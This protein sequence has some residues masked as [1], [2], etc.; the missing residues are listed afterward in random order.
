MVLEYPYTLMIVTVAN[1][2]KSMY[3]KSIVVYKDGENV[4]GLGEMAMWGD[5]MSQVTFLSDGYM[6]HLSLKVSADNK[7]N[8]DKAIELAK[9]VK[10]RL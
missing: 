2:N 4:S 9:L 1:A 5:S 10:E 3:E 7:D 6:I 8:K